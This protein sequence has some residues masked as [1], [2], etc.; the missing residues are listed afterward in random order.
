MNI[1]KRQVKILLD[2]TKNDTREVLTRL[3]IDQH[4]GRTY[5]VCTDSYRLVAIEIDVASDVIGKTVTRDE[6]EK[7]YKLANSKDVL[8]DQDI[9]TLA[10]NSEQPS[11]LI[12]YPAWRKIVPVAE[13]VAETSISIN[14]RYLLDF[15]ILADSNLVYE[16]HDQLYMAKSDMGIFI[17]MG[18][19]K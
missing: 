6:L 4:D 8:T 5:L 11:H 19:R 2:I 7:W 15:D 14:G 3:K 9:E 13:P 17:V 12:Q 1:T 18:L 16:L 10:K